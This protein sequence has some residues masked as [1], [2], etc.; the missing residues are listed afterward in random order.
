MAET[1]NHEESLREIARRPPRMTV[2]SDSP[3]EKYTDESFELIYKIGSVYD[4]LRHSGT[5]TPMA[6][7]LYGDWGTG[8]T[9]AMRFL[10]DMLEDWNDSPK[11]AKNDHF[12]V[13]TVW[14]DPWKYQKREDVWRGLIAELILKSLILRKGKDKNFK[15]KI[16]SAAKR[17]GP[18]L[19]K[20][21]LHALSG[22]KIGT[23]IVEYNFETAQQIVDEWE[24]AAHPEKA[25]LNDFEDTLKDWLEKTIGTDDKTRMA[26]FIDDLD[27]CMPEVAL[28]VL[29]ALKLYLAIP[30]LIFIIGVDP[31]VVNALIE[32]HYEKLGVEKEKAKKYLGKM[33]QVEVNITPSQSQAERFFER[34]I[35]E[36]D[37][38]IAGKESYW[39]KMMTDEQRD[40]IYPILQNMAQHNPREIK[41]ILNN[42]LIYGTGAA[43]EKTEDQENRFAQGVQTYLISRALDSFTT[44]RGEWLGTKNYLELFNDWSKIVRDNPDLETPA[45][46]STKKGKEEEITAA[47]GITGRRGEKGEGDIFSAIEEPYKSFCSK[48]TPI[49]GLGSLRQ[50]FDCPFLFELMKIE[51]STDVAGRMAFQTARKDEAPLPGSDNPIMK[52]IAADLK[53]PAESLTPDDLI[54][55]TSLDLSGLKLSD[56]KPIQGLTNLQTLYLNS[57]QVSDLK[58]IQGLTDLQELYLADSQVSDLKPIQGLTNLQTLYLNSTQVSDLKPIQGLTNLQALYLNS[59]QVSDLSPIQGLTNLQELFLRETQVSDLKPIQGLSNLQRLVLDGTQVSDLKPIQGLT[60]LQT[61][62]FNSTQVS[63]LKPIQGLTNLQRLDLNKTQVS[64]LKP[65]QGLTNL[66]LLDLE[67][68]QVSDLKPIQGLTNLQSLYLERTQV[69]DL[70]PIHNLKEL[71]T[72]YLDENWKRSEVAKELK[73]NLPEVNI[74]YM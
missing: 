34:Q 37:T 16:A 57:T 46:S 48:W 14:F 59:T 68:T 55:V 12:T 64:D 1:N 58:P 26:I 32:N 70:S 24:K 39:Q 9:S 61:L 63:D 5:K 65:I 30:E 41:R 13:H 35:R 33:F 50:L 28:E 43:L 73:K 71:A 10:K 62:Y 8:K 36:L 67:G 23:E 4:I 47:P 7:S 53:K 72:L 52:K 45:L 49:L 74:A 56:L 69:S 3:L 42:A 31:N 60:N 40:I 2:L 66:Q 17:F 6:I 25:Y 27:R 44:I 20:S 29:E 19:G 18:F 51:F 15:D 54:S 21:F 38:M 11:N 22:L